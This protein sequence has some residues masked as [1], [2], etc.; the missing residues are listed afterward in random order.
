MEERKRLFG[1]E[2]EEGDESDLCSKMLEY[3]K[4]L[5]YIEM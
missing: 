4:G 3:F 5:D 2:S 1:G